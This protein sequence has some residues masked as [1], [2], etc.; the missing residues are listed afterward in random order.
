MDAGV[1]QHGLGEYQEV[2]HREAGV[3]RITQTDIDAYLDVLCALAEQRMLASDGSPLLLTPT[4]SHWFNWRERQGF[5]ILLRITS[6][7]AGRLA[8][9]CA[10]AAPGGILELLRKAV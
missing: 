9:W 1:E 8:V 2:L 7:R 6:G 4:M 3:L 10:S 5:G